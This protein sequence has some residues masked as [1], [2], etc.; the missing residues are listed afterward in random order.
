MIGCCL[1]INIVLQTITFHMADALMTYVVPH[2][3]F[4]S[5][6]LPGVGCDVKLPEIFLKI[7]LVTS[8]DS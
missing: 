4:K 6:F 8:G 5:D 1:P 7:V 2:V 3:A